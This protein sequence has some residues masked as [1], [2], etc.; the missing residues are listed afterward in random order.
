MILISLQKNLKKL[1]VLNGKLTVCGDVLRDSAAVKT[2][3][4][5]DSVVLVEKRGT[6]RLDQIDGEVVQLQTLGKEILGIVLL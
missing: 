6:S 3:A 5:F 1:N 2:L 4:D